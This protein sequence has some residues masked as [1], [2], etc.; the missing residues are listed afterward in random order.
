MC[1]SL[2]PDIFTSLLS[3]QGTKHKCKH[4][5]YI[6]SSYTHSCAH[7]YQSLPLLGRPVSAAIWPAATWRRLLTDCSALCRSRGHFVLRQTKLRHIKRLNYPPG[8]PVG[9]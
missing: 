9:L 7:L 6:V 5:L 2:I 4:Y 1:G 8:T 3:L